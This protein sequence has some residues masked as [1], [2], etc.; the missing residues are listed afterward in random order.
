MKIADAV[1]VSLPLF[2]C[3]GLAQARLQNFQHIVVLIQENRTP[4][5]LFQGLCLPPYGSPS[6][7]GTGANQFDIQ[8]FGFDRKGNVIPLNAV[9]FTNG[10]DPNHAHSAFVS[11]CNPNTTTYFPCR[12]NTL[13]LTTKCP[14]AC[15]FQYVDPVQ[16]PMLSPYYYI[17][18]NFGWANR[19]F[20]T[21][22]GSSGPAHQYLFSGTSAATATDDQN[23]LFVAENISG[24]GCLGPAGYSFK[25]ID[26]AHVPKIYSVSE[27]LGFG[28]FSHDTLAAELEKD[29]ANGGLGNTWSYYTVGVQKKHTSNNIWTAPNWIYEIC[30]PNST[31]TQCTGADWINNVYM[32]PSQ[33]LTDAANCQLKN[34]VWVTPTGQNSDHASVDGTHTGGPA[35]VANVINAIGGSTCDDIINGVRVPYWQDTA[36]LVTWDDW[37]GYYDHVLPPFLSAPKQGQG[38]YQLGF[39]VPLLFVSA[40]T[41]PIIDSTNQYDFG[42]ILRFVEHNFGITEGIMGFADARASTDLSA[43]YDLGLT[44]KQF[45]IPTNVGPDFFIHDKRKPDPP[46]TD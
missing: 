43:F 15:S 37:G 36:I 31:F 30:Q 10:F 11:M 40:Y 7:C 3:L 44:P 18:Q 45:H 34:M 23:A 32:N 5:N 27:P 20:Q 29:G 9:P 41:N 2:L 19:M 25:F 39:R 26:P 24:L 1:K 17:A 22:Q 33:V 21:N 4:D 38:D 12:A 6:A 8:S 13:L 16:S 14:L 28:C 46:D 35:W 42:S